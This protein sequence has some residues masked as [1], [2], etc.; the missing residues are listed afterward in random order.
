MDFKLRGQ[1]LLFRQNPG[2]FVGKRWTKTKS[3][4]VSHAAMEECQNTPLQIDEEFS[5]ESSIDSLET[6]LNK[7]KLKV[8][9][10]PKKKLLVDKP[11]KTKKLKATLHTCGDCNEEFSS[12]FKLVKHVNLWH[13]ESKIKVSI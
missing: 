5:S 13:K 2:I 10:K 12:Q 8:K 3:V 1:N 4:S 9:I 11:Q 6:P 7:T